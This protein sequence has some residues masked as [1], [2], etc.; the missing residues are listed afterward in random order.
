MNIAI[1]EDSIAE[2]T[3]LES[4]LREYAAAHRVSLELTRFDRAEDLLEN[5]RPLQYTVIFLDIFM[6]G[7][8]G[9][10]AA[11][12]IRQQDRDTILVFLTTSE[13]YRAEALHYHA[14]DYITKPISRED[15][16]RVM[17]D[18]LAQYTDTDTGRLSFVSSRQEYSLPYSDIVA[19]RTDSANYLE[20]LDKSGKSYRTRMTFS[21]VTDQ[22]SQDS[23][24]LRILRGIYVNMDYVTGFRDG[25]CQLLSCPPLPMNVR[26]ARQIEQVW[27]NYT[28]SKIRTE[29]LR[30]GGIR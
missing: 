8:T 13:E 4:I 24:F 25:T 17:D 18:I 6:I 30:S 28:F 10:Q 19:V 21:A 23:R 29:A 26:Y 20:I 7:T 9:I 14:F 27:K 11:A 12:E 5:Y 2:R 3:L 22:L 1:V 16:F 15:I